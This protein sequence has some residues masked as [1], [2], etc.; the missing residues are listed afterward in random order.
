MRA[1]M[2]R[3]DAPGLLARAR[4]PRDPH[5]PQNLGSRKLG[6]HGRQIAMPAEG[7]LAHLLGASRRSIPLL[8]EREGK[9]RDGPSWGP[10][11]TKSRD[12]GALAEDLYC[13]RLTCPSPGQSAQ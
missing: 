11:I 2:E 4:A 5:F 10:E 6:V 12:S 7:G 3:R 13:V 1:A 9:Q 8:C